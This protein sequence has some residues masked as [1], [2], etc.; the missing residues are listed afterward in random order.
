MSQLESGTFIYKSKV[1]FAGGLA[2]NY[3]LA[4]GMKRP[5]IYTRAGEILRTGETPDLALHKFFLNFNANAGV[6]VNKHIDVFA[7][8][9]STSAVNEIV[10]NIAYS[11]M[12]F[13]VNY[14]F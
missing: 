6:V 9:A 13:G 4:S 14:L 3:V 5:V 8:I 7:G 11:T 10:T 12:Y 2:Y 1:Y